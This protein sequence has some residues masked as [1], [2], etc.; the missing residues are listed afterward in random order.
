MQQTQLI[1]DIDPGIDDALA[2]AYACSHT[3]TIDLL[4]V[5]CIYGNVPVQQAGQN[6]LALLKLLDREEVPV[7]LGE[8]NPMQAL[9]YEVSVDAKRKHGANGLGNIDLPTSDRQIEET[10]AVDFLLEAAKTYGK[11][12]AI[13]AAGPLTNIAAC[14]ERDPAFLSRIGHLVVMGGAFLI[15][16]SVTSFAET[17]TSKDP[18]ASHQ[19]VSQGGPISIVGLDVTLRTL[20]PESKARQWFNSSDPVRQKLGQMACH[21]I[22]AYQAVQPHT[23]GCPIHDALAL[24]AVLAPEDFSFLKLPVKVEQ[25]GVARGRMVGDKQRLSD[26]ASHVQVAVNLDVTTFEKSFLQAIESRRL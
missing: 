14:L 21:Y 5:T 4:A 3:T 6:A 9:D 10:A 19:V 25:T 15:E 1:M 2:L 24:H 7:Y 8:A 17:N 22:E 11:S 16:G 13:L 23:I 12:L 26:F 18:Q 20:L